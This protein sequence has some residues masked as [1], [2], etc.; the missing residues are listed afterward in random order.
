MSPLDG[1][2][3][4]EQSTY[5]KIQGLIPAEASTEKIAKQLKLTNVIS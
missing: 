2:T 5:P 3:V 4:V 1:N